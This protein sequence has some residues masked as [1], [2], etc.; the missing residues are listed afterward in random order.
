LAEKH[1]SFDTLAGL[2]FFG[3]SIDIR[4]IFLL[5]LLQDVG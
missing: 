5:V 4:G 3:E 1:E 2:I